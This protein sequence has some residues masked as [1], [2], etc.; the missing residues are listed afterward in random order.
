MTGGIVISPYCRAL[1]MPIRLLTPTHC[2][3]H[4]MCHGGCE[5]YTVRLS[6][7]VR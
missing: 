7:P 1:D 5:H 4:G 2:S 6:M 3:L